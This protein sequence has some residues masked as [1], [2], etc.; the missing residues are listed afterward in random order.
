MVVRVLI[1]YIIIWTRFG[2]SRITLIRWIS[3]KLNEMKYIAL[4]DEVL[5]EYRDLYIGDIGFFKII[6]P[7]YIYTLSY[8]IKNGLSQKILV[9]S[10]DLQLVRI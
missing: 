8:L 10:N 1:L 5:L 9:L 2:Y 4:L 7:Q 6:K 3:T